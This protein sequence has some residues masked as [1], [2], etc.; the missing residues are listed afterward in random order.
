MVNKPSIGH[1]EK[2][3][4]AVEKVNFRTW[5]VQGE[6]KSFKIMKQIITPKRYYL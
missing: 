3:Q 6:I 5:P 4:S 1:G 2:L